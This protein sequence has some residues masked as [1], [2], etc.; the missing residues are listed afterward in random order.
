MSIALPFM[1]VI[2]AIILTRHSLTI[3]ADATNTVACSDITAQYRA[4]VS[5]TAEL[6]SAIQHAQPGDLI[7][8]ADGLYE[9]PFTITLSGTAELP[10]TI[11]GSEKAI[12]T[13]ADVSRKYVISLNHVS[14]WHMIGITLTLGKKGIMLD[15]THHCILDRLIV[16]NIGQEAV[17]FRTNST[18]NT[19]SNSWIYRTGRTDSQYGEGIYIGSAKSNLVGDASNFNRV[20][21]NRIG[22]D[23]T[24][25][26]ID[27]K[28]YTSNGILAGN[29]FSGSGLTGG[30]TDSFV[31][32]K[33]NNYT[34]ENNY[35]S[36]DSSGLTDAFQTHEVVPGWGWYNTFNGNRLDD[37]APGYI[38]N[39]QLS[40]KQTNIV[41]C[42]NEGN[43]ATKG[44][45][46]VTCRQNGTVFSAA[47][48]YPNRVNPGIA[49]SNVTDDYAIPSDP[50]IY[51]G[52]S[53]N[54]RPTTVSVTS[55]ASDRSDRYSMLV[56]ILLAIT[57]VVA[58]SNVL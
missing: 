5:T 4:P 46:H 29:R 47:L 12:L 51:P 35:G 36:S 42:T 14:Y 39:P 33:G 41:T 27:V 38:V 10:I 54:P 31:D 17:H 28:E 19:I 7:V 40:G 18:N 44:I 58:Q 34:I 45:T 25:E 1:I 16:Y 55:L 8:L 43:G 9:A 6:I 49:S 57:T 22:P 52:T 50:S 3:Q 32:V 30:V 15:G 24:A 21:N 48:A 37:S 20:L 56:I 11:C 13:G 53:S 23:V 26:C 2:I